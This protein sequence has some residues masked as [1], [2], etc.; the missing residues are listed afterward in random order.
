MSV[1]GH[2]QKSSKTILCNLKAF[3][4]CFNYLIITSFVNAWKIFQALI[5]LDIYSQRSVLSVFILTHVLPP[6]L[7]AINI[8]FRKE[9]PLNSLPLLAGPYCCTDIW[10][11]Q[12]CWSHKSL[13]LQR[14]LLPSSKDEIFGEE[15]DAV[16]ALNGK[17]FLQQCNGHT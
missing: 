5:Y 14:I 11:R 13:T 4:R 8:I 10:A 7:R 12:S 1:V 3:G 2:Y 15:F 9:L 6:P 17:P 16:V